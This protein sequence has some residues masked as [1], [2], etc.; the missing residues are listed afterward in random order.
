MNMNWKDEMS[1]ERASVHGDLKYLRA[2]NH[3]TVVFWLC[4]L[5]RALRWLP[6]A[7]RSEELQSDLY[8]MF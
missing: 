6:S 2:V 4:C 1:L 5:L 8:V 7:P 3:E